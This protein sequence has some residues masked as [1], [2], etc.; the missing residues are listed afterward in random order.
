FLQHL[1]FF[2]RE[3]LS[4]EDAQRTALYR[5]HRR[6][7]LALREAT[8]LAEFLATLELRGDVRSASSDQILRIAQLSQRTNQFNATGITFSP[9]ELQRAVQQGLEVMS[10][11]V[12]DRFGKYGLVGAAIYRL[13]DESLTIEAFYLSCRVLGRGVEHR[14]LAELG[15]I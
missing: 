11:E 3:T 5:D 6:R 4:R 1:W 2:D 15:R 14:I 10:V 12:T 7:D 8:S 9:L 13:V